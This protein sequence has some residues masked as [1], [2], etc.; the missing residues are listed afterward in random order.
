LSKII[1]ASRA[2]K[3]ALWQAEHIKSR[4]EELFP[5][6]EVSILEIT[7][8]GDK[9]L[10]RPLALIGGKGHFTKELEDEMLAGN[11]DIAVHSLKDVPTFIPEG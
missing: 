9:I 1:I 2:S 10:D 4:I 3:L 7:S 11:A 6:I 8:R 5:S